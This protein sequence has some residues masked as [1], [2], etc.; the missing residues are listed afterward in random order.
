MNFK[1]LPHDIERL[2]YEYDDTYKPK[3]NAL[4]NPI[5]MDIVKQEQLE[6]INYATYEYQEWLSFKKRL[7]NRVHSFDTMKEISEENLKVGDIFRFRVCTYKYIA[8]G[9]ITRMTKKTIFYKF[10]KEEKYSEW[11]NNNDWG[12]SETLYKFNINNIYDMKE[13]R[14]KKKTLDIIDTDKI[15]VNKN[16]YYK[17]HISNMKHDL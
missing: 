3:R 1:N 4:W 11:F 16:F 14:M 8:Y 15:N 5:F 10:L 17:G 7:Y 9:I 6:P 13:K 12:S 2:I